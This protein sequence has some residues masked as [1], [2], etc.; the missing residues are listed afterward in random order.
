[1]LSADDVTVGHMNRATPPNEFEVR[2]SLYF[3]LIYVALAVA[4]AAAAASNLWIQLATREAL[5]PAALFAVVTLFF[6]WQAVEQM[7]DRRPQIAIGRDG[8]LLAAASSDFIPWRQIRRIERGRRL[9]GGPRFEIELAPEAAGRLKFG[10]RFMGDHVTRLPG[11]PN[12]V[13]V[14]TMGLD[15]P[16]DDIHAAVRRHWPPDELAQA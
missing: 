9:F 10:F 15:R 2:R 7:R 16:L 3:S 11:N 6:V 12:G 5:T 13:T 1:M 14:F 8:L 4:L